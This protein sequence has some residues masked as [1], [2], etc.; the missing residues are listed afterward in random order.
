M[1]GEFVNQAMPNGKVAP[2]LAKRGIVGRQ[3]VNSDVGYVYFNMDDPTVGGYTPTRWRCGARSAWLTNVE[4]EIRTICRGQAIPAQSILQPHTYGYDP[5]FK[6]EM[7]DHDP[8]RA[9]ALLDLYGYKDVD[10]DGWRELPDG[11][12]LVIT[13]STLPEQITASSTRCGRRT[14]TPSASAPCSAYR[15]SPRA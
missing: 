1:P 12:P 5:T 10:G 6:S 8:A 14:W 15:S 4:R 9:K 3:Q 2:N 13:R 11:K 7:G